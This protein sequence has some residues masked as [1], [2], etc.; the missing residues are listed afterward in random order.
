MAIMTLRFSLNNN[1]TPPKHT[2]E[3]LGGGILLADQ[4]RFTTHLLKLPRTQ[5]SG[6]PLSGVRS[7]LKKSSSFSPALE[8]TH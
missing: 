7:A 2:V 8:A 1:S 5:I 4:N 3:H 6:R